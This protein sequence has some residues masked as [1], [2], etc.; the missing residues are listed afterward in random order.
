M[1]YIDRQI[2]SIDKKKQ[3]LQTI[4]SIQS[5]EQDSLNCSLKEAQESGDINI[6]SF[7]SALKGLYIQY[8]VNHKIGLLLFT[9]KEYSPN[10]DY[11]DT[12]Y[13][14]ASKLGAT[15]KTSEVYGLLK[16]FSYEFS[17]LLLLKY[18]NTKLSELFDI[19]DEDAFKNELEKADAFNLLLIC[20]FKLSLEAS[21]NPD[22]TDIKNK[23][24]DDEFKGI[25]NNVAMN[26]DESGSLMINTLD[27]GQVEKGMEMMPFDVVSK[28]IV[29][30]FCEAFEF[31]PILSDTEIILLNAVYEKC[32]YKDDLWKLYFQAYADKYGIEQLNEHINY[33]ITNYPDLADYINANKN[34]YLANEQSE[35]TKDECEENSIL[36]YDENPDVTAIENSTCH[37]PAKLE[38]D[39][40]E[41]RYSKL[42]KSEHYEQVKEFFSNIDIYDKGAL[43]EN[44]IGQENQK[45]DVYII[46]FWEKIYF[47]A[48]NVNDKTGLLGFMFIMYESNCF[49][50]SKMISIL[51]NRMYNYYDNSDNAPI[52][53]ANDENSKMQELEEIFKDK[54]KP[55]WKAIKKHIQTMFNMMFMLE[56]D[57][58]EIKCNSPANG[59][60]SAL[61]KF[62]KNNV[63][64]DFGDC[65][66][67]KFKTGKLEKINE[68]QKKSNDKRRG[69]RRS[70]S[71]YSQYK[72]TIEFDDNKHSL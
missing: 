35:V 54:E 18:G 31:I 59:E 29:G 38:S 43:D 24:S 66:G 68:S 6:Q 39:D 34:S 41:T 69:K 23:V 16:S 42:R 13:T 10:L 8:Y 53:F 49:N 7:V 15:C 40:I 21:A 22:I 61:L 25:L 36:I 50:W 12:Y 63:M 4:V 19:G 26:L 47:I 2:A 32:F 20:G 14:L 48:T 65:F 72:K 62:S 44:R 30:T 28:N 9:I 60:I 52:D 5:E 3:Q 11:L 27:M 37:G 58:G 56:K 46:R 57:F 1:D 71:Q 51:L 67:Y 55:Q 70:G 64:L 45:A 17:R 33:L